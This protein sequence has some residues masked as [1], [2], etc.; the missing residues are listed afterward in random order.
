MLKLKLQYFG[1]LMRSAESLEK[2][3]L[4]GKDPDAGEDWKQGE[5]GVNR[6]WDDWIASP[7]HWT[8]VWANSGRWWRTGKPSMLQSMGL[9]SQ[10]WLSDWTTTTRIPYRQSCWQR[11]H[12][13]WRVPIQCLRTENSSV[14]RGMR[15]CKPETIPSWLIHRAIPNTGDN[16][17]V[18]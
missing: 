15:G 5:N 2:T 6:G 9:Q 7:T 12:L 16:H 13:V 10:T 17:L 11:K 4:I 1:H 14:G 3:Q 8:W 18:S